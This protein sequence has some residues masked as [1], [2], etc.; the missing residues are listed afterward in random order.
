[1]LGVRGEWKLD[2]YE[3]WP[4]FPNLAYKKH[5][6]KTFYWKFQP[7]PYS[8]STLF[9]DFMHAF[10]KLYIYL[11]T[12]TFFRHIAQRL[13]P[14]PWRMLGVNDVHVIH[15]LIAFANLIFTIFFL[16]FY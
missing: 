4:L 6:I 14:G 7:F 15:Y 8:F 13:S 12:F 1:M 11:L 16:F 9:L 2:E 5:H 3:A 10:E